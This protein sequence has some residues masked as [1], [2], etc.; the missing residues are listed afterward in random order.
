[1]NKCH[2]RMSLVAIAAIA[3][4]TGCTPKPLAN[5][6]PSPSLASPS[7]TS[8]DATVPNLNKAYESSGK[9]YSNSVMRGQQAFFL[10]KGKF[11]STV[12]ELGLGI[13][14]DTES[15]KFEVAEVKPKQVKVTATA[16]K[17]EIKSYTVSVFVVG[18]TGNELTMGIV[19]ATDQPSQTPPEVSTPPKSATDVLTCPTG[20]SAA[21]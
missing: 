9:L 17:P 3:F 21:N 11:A 1:M 6:T 2:F 18:E 12:D 15:Y 19:C 5:S 13:K 20:S 8:T 10:E 4:S 16:K 14:T 7:P